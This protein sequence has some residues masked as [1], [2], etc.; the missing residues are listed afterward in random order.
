M[1][2]MKGTIMWAIVVIIYFAYQ[3]TSKNHDLSIRISQWLG[4]AEG[5]VIFILAVAMAILI[6]LSLCTLFWE[7]KDKYD[8]EDENGSNLTLW[9]QYRGIMIIL[10]SILLF[11]LIAIIYPI[12]CIHL[13]FDIKRKFYY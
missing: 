1:R 12:G 10:I 3:L 11:P 13:F 4:A 7:I 5:A 6:P 2:R 8:E 9:Q